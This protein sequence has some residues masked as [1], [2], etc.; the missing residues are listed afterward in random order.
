LNTLDKL[1]GYFA[2]QAAV[3]RMEARAT[4]QQVAQLTGSG[5][6]PYT[7]AKVS[8]L[9][10]LRRSVLKENEVSESALDQLRADSWHLYRNNPSARKIVRSLEA[11]VIG[12]GMM[13]ESLARNIDGSPAVEFRARAKEL[14]QAIQ[15]GFD[16]R[17]LPG[18]GGLTFCG[19]Q[20]LALR[21][22]I[23]S[24][25]TLFRMRTI[26][27]R[28]RIAHDLP[29]NVALQMVDA[30]RLADESEVVTGTLASGNVIYR[31]IELNSEGERVSYWLRSVPVW[32][33]AADRGVVSRVPVDKI[34]HLFLEEDIDQLRGVPW[35]A[36]AIIGIRDTG[37]LQYNVLKASA[38]AAC[39]VGTYAKPT[40]A[41]RVG[42]N[43]SLN[44]SQTSADGTDLTD[45]D[46]NQITKLQPAMLINTGKDGKF[47][48]HSPN[49]PN[50]NPEG[51]VQHLQRGTA[52]AIPGIKSSTITG[53]Y[54]QSSF[55][56]ERSADNDI[57]PELHDVQE[58]FSSSFCQPI[59]ES[60][61]RAAVFNGY[62]A[63]IV[64]ATEFAADPG[65]FSAAKWQG[66]VALSI[67]PRDDAEAASARISGGISSLQMECAKVNVNWRDVLN[68][69]AELYAVAK[70]KGIPQEVVNNIMGVDAQD[71]LAAAVASTT[72]A[73]EAP[74]ETVTA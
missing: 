19:L 3:R 65:R 61:L 68:D 45:A 36:S 13:P 62:F 21:S 11:K 38:M 54:R 16:A 64:D 74:G 58:W 72:Q 41:Q 59:Y 57:W 67:N 14:W 66:P 55:S 73:Q 60:V 47:E 51:F 26:T 12:R 43:Q 40:G 70:E 18:R 1:I 30:C 7:A 24:G 53:D 6:G 69:T 49:Q 39:V 32:A 34:G 71:Q 8:R 42:L 44:S 56:S 50:M 25:D 37:D 2:P 22:V 63:G 33:S 20:K 52:T 29:V 31:G 9:S 27:D 23:L 46:G 35:F 4:L 15:S 5:I 28:K 10:G 48:L 17:G